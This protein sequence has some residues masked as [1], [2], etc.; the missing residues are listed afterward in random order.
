M[1]PKYHQTPFVDRTRRLRERKPTSRYI[2]MYHSVA[3]ELPTIRRK[4]AEEV[5]RIKSEQNKLYNS[6][7][8]NQSE[9]MMSRDIEE[10]K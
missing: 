8:P 3:R 1:T 10:E 7:K 5:E 6:Y 9:G 4:I 2:C